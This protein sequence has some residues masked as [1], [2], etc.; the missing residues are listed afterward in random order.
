MAEPADG[1]R[2]L[3]VIRGERVWRGVG[4]AGCEAGESCW[5][6]VRSPE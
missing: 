6:A 1:Q 4:G 5:A 2:E 3:R